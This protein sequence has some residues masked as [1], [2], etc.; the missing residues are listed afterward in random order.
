MAL[1]V[2]GEAVLAQPVPGRPGLDPGEVDAAD[3]ELGEQFHQRAGVVLTQEGDQRGPVGAGCG[4]HRARPAHHHEPGHRIRHV[5][6]LAGQHGQPVPA[7][8]E[9]TGQRGVDLPVGGLARG[10]GV[11]RRGPPLRVGQVLG[12]PVPA[13]R[14][15]LR[16]AAHR[17]DVRQPRAFPDQQGERHRQ[18]EF[19][20]DGQIR[21][22]GELIQGGGDRPL[23]RIL[24]RHDGA[25]R[26]SAAHGVQRG[27]DART[28]H[29]PIQRRRFELRQRGFGK[30]PLGPQICITD[31]H[32][33]HLASRRRVAGTVSGLWRPR[34][35]PADGTVNGGAEERTVTPAPPRSF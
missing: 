2:D 23:Y 13:L 18:Q 10:L 30:C 26:R 22:S 34:P 28:R 35:G 29:R 1:A 25:L 19:R 14:L 5:V 27:R 32:G 33:P 15:R 11:R 17:L 21:A 24:D 9:H 16:M 31:W 4:G 6:H 20:L 7:G 12:E 8:G 3:G